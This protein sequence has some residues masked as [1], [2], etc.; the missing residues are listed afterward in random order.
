MSQNP[1][2][3]EEA[4]AAF[5]SLPV[6]GKVAIGAVVVAGILS[7]FPLVRLTNALIGPRPTIAPVA[8]AEKQTKERSATFSVFVDQTAGRSLFYNPAL[9]TA[10]PPP[11]PD[12]PGDIAPPK[13]TSYGGP[14]ILAMIFDEVW[15]TDGTRVRLGETK[16]DIKIVAMNPPWDA[17]IAWKGVDF[18]VELFQKNTVVFKESAARSA[19]PEPAPSPAPSGDTP[20]SSA[21][22]T[23]APVDETPKPVTPGTTP[24]T[25]EPVKPPEPAP[26]PTTPETPRS[27]EPAQPKDATPA[28]DSTR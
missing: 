27:P 14:A 25:T 9:A 26:A 12:D 24:G 3:I 17:T 28:K 2:P 15:F 6:P 10:P 19:T 22:T 18:K 11:P 1:A 5:A 20:A 16:D 13:P 7:I 23:P 21:E 4:R 8:E